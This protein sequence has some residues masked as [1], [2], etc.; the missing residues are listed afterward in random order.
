MDMQV[1]LSCI[2]AMFSVI[3]CQLC[4]PGHFG[5][6]IIPHVQ[7]SK[8]PIFNSEL[9]KGKLELFVSIP[10]LNP[11]VLLV[12]GERVVCTA[13][14]PHLYILS[15]ISCKCSVACHSSSCTLT[16]EMNWV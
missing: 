15:Y 1:V 16:L 7:F 8:N 9:H 14:S 12:L 2:V 6:M 11:H 10:Q 4:T 13:I 3:K 5:T